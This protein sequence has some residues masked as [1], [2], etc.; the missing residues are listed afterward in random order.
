MSASAIATDGAHDA[1]FESDDVTSRSKAR[2]S[3]EAIS[4]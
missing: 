1:G 3:G 2:A 4:E